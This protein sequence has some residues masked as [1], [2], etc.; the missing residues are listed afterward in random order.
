MNWVML[1]L[2]QNCRIQTL[3]KISILPRGMALGYTL[4]VPVEDKY[5]IS[6]EEIKNQIKINGGRIAEELISMKLSGASNDIERATNWQNNLYVIM[7]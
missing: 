2:L 3:H 7:E 6:T 4:Q 1:L 5:L